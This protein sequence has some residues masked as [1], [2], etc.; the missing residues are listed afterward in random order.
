MIFAKKT[1]FSVPYN[2]WLKGP[3][4]QLFND[5]ILELKGN[6]CNILDWKYIEKL[7]HENVNG[8][9]NNG[10]ILWKILNL[11]IWLSNNER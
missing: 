7:L 6:N 11:M 3:L 2:L 10:F 8:I 4:N 1:G 5:K 9:R